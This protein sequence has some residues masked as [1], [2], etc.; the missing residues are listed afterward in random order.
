[1]SEVRAEEMAHQLRLPEARKAKEVLT[2]RD[3]ALT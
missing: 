3:S 1:M 2:A